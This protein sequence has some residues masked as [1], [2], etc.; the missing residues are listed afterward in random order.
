VQL[1]QAAAWSPN[2]S[3]PP[4]YFDLP[5]ENGEVNTLALAKWNANVPLAMIDQYIGNL[6]KYDAIGIEVG[7]KD[8]LMAS[9]EQI[10]DVLTSYGI[11]HL[12]ETFDG[13]HTN[14]AAERYETRV[15]PF[16]SEHLAF[17]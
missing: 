12:F 15:L 5:L 16:F 17:K 9:N 8:G 3:R 1:T 13:D 11:D 7:T 14:R 4:L 2:P 10:S 6:R